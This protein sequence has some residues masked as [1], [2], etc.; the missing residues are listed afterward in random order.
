M[1]R[2]Q[3]HIHLLTFPPG[4]SL[5]ILCSSIA[6]QQSEK[7][8]I[9]EIDDKRKEVDAAK[10]AELQKVANASA[11]SINTITTFEQLEDICPDQFPIAFADMSASNSTA[12]ADLLATVSFPPSSN[13][14]PVPSSS[15]ADPALKSLP[16]AAPPL[17]SKAISADLPCDQPPCMLPYIK[18]ETSAKSSKPFSLQK[19]LQTVA[20]PRPSAP[21]RASSQDDDFQPEKVLVKRVIKKES[22]N[23][24]GAGPKAS[25]NSPAA[26]SASRVDALCILPDAAPA[27]PASDT[28]PLTSAATSDP[29][30]AS[31]A[32]AAASTPATAEPEKK[33]SLSRIYICSRTHS[34]LSQLIK[35]LK[36]TVYTPNMAILG[37]REQMCIHPTVMLSEA[38]NEDCSKLIGGSDSSGCSFF[39]GANALANHPSM[40]VVWDI[41]DIVTKGRQFRACPYFTAKD[42]AE[43]SDVVFCPYNYLIDKLIRE[44]SGIDLKNNIVIFDEAHNL[45]DQCRDAASFVVTV[46]LLNTAIDMLNACKHFPNCP[47]DVAALQTAF[48]EIRNWIQD[49]EGVMTSDGS[50]E[51]ILEF[52]ADQVPQQLSLMHLTSE[53][54][55]QLA[56]SANKMQEWHKEVIEL[57]EAPDAFRWVSPADG[58]SHS[59]VPAFSV[60]MRTVEMIVLVSGYA[61][62]FKTDYAICLQ[63]KPMDTDTKVNI[64]CLNPGVAFRDLREQCRS[65]VLTSGAPCNAHSQP[66]NYHYHILTAL[67]TPTGT[68]SPMDS[69]S[70]ELGCDFSIRLEAPHVIDCARQVMCN[71]MPEFN[72][73]FKGSDSLAL[74]HRL[75]Q[76][77]IDVCSVTPNG[78]LV[79][80]ASYW[81][82][83]MLSQTWRANGQW[84]TL[85]ALKSVYLEPKFN[86][87]NFTKLLKNFEAAAC[88][89]KGAVMIAVCRGK[90]SE[91]LDLSDRCCL[92]F[93]STIILR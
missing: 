50:G 81:W 58:K 53:M 10:A 64:W 71:Y 21:S 22:V 77:I 45:E 86:D 89:T 39:Q 74:H 87:K 17:H 19:T 32:A 59:V 90:I 69:F 78:V 5:A 12:T 29:P 31:V 33:E 8:R 3:L 49:R 79:F 18:S 67:I 57:S 52:V 82:I 65:V 34:Q 28:N 14:T 37:S 75:G 73:S 85:N 66:R 51:R 26:C 44:S 68:L 62:E 38:K 40:R 41:E 36:S 23:T 56:S 15:T 93:G 54:V 11:M 24:A 60:C 70:S 4:K 30:V 9:K 55:K 80:C 7:A 13:P 63:R 61:H 2:H 84:D 48:F 6:W 16:A 43:K 1:Q 83:E 42:I 35:G 47:T 25:M 88:T 27:T 91:G 72:L 20:P 46:T 76:L 92:I